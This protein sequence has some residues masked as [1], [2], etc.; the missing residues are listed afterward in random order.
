MTLSL[1]YIYD[2][3]ACNPVYNWIIW[4]YSVERFVK[5]AHHVLGSA[6]HG[7]VLD[8]GCASVACTASTYIQYSEPAVFLL[9]QSLKMLRLAKSRLVR[10]NGKVPDNMVFIRADALSLP[11]REN[12]FNMILSEN[13]LHC[14][15]DTKN[16]LKSLNRSSPTTLLITN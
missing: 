2:W 16:L 7:N 11:F 13:L 8:L 10:I 4:G 1:E 9:D 3:V 15:D 6:G 14:L 5:I 12:S